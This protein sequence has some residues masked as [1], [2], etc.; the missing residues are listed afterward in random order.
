M[1]KIYLLTYTY[2]SIYIFDSLVTVMNERM[3]YVCMKVGR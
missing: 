1:R 3:I 2:Q